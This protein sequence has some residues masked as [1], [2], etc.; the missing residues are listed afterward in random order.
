MCIQSLKRRN[1]ESNKRNEF[2]SVLWSIIITNIVCK[3]H[4]C[5]HSNRYT[6]N[7][8]NI[9][10]GKK[11]IS[12]QSSAHTVKNLV[13]VDSDSRGNLR[14]SLRRRMTGGVN[15]YETILFVRHHSDLSATL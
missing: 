3:V 11:T 10:P 9:M 5:T 13:Y 6:D 15:V 14:K 8:A 2:A 4:V 7:N 12:R 1:S